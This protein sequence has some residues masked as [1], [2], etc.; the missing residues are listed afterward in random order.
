MSSGRLHQTVG[1]AGSAPSVGPRGRLYPDEHLTLR[2]IGGPAYRQSCCQIG[3]TRE[4]TLSFRQQPLSR[5][6]FLWA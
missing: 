2:Q 1:R 3:N 4:P 5:H 6:C